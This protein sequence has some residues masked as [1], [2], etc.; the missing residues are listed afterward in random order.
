MCFRR[1]M[2]RLLFWCAHAP[3]ACLYR[4]CIC[5]CVCLYQSLR[6][7]NNSIAQDHGQLMLSVTKQRTTR[8]RALPVSGLARPA[9]LM[10]TTCT[11]TNT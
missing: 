11:H 8:M 6:W 10:S 3:V 9:V 5:V 7:H 4:L 1:F 2:H